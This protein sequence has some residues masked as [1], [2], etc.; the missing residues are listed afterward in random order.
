MFNT[1]SISMQSKRMR[2]RILFHIWFPQDIF[3]CR[4]IEEAME[5]PSDISAIYIYRNA[6]DAI[7]DGYF[8]P[9]MKICGDT[10]SMLDIPSCIVCYKD[11]SERWF[12][13]SGQTTTTQLLNRVSFG[14]LSLDDYAVLAF[15]QQEDGMWMFTAAESLVSEPCTN[16]SN[17][18]FCT[19]DSLLLAYRPNEDMVSFF[20]TASVFLPN[21][22]QAMILSGRAVVNSGH[23]I[24]PNETDGMLILRDSY[25]RELWLPCRVSERMPS[26]EHRL[27]DIL[28]CYGFVIEDGVGEPLNT[29]LNHAIR[30]VEMVD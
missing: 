12:S 30:S 18:F 27:S 28:S 26:G 29:W 22:T 20:H 10:V 15:R 2:N 14:Q 23:V 9:S 3:S 1:A 7:L 4:T 11:N 25:N 19:E 8:S 16:K 17:A 24:E 21:P 5:R 6:C 13:I